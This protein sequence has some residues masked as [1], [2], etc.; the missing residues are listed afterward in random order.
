MSDLLP[1][2]AG[3]GRELAIGLRGGV[4]AG[5]LRD[6]DELLFLDAVGL[7]GVLRSVSQADM[8]NVNTKIVVKKEREMCFFMRK[9][10]C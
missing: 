3:A 2:R 7:A 9:L 4:F 6:M 8:K 5:G 10:V 1:E